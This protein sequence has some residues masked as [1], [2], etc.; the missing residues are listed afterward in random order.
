VGTGNLTKNTGFDPRYGADFEAES[1]LD[2]KKLD[3]RKRVLMR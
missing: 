2:D 3:W 1:V